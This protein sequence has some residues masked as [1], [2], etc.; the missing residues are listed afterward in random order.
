MFWAVHIHTAPSLQEAMQKQQVGAETVGLA[1]EKNEA[2]S[3]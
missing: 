2:P 3:G 1:T